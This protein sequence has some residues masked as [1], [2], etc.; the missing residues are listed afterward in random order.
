MALGWQFL[1]KQDNAVPLGGAGLEKIIKIV[2]KYDFGKSGGS[3]FTF[4]YSL[5]FIQ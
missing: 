5:E 1:D 3:D 4:N 2:K